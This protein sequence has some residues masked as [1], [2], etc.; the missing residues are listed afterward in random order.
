MI[1]IMV[2][3]GFF[4]LGE[5]YAKLFGCSNSVADMVA[6]GFRIYAVTFLVMGYDVIN[7][8]YFY[9]LWRC[10]IISFDFVTKGNCVASGIYID[11]SGNIWYDR[12]MGGITLFGNF[13]CSSFIISDW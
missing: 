12:S 3:V 6:A 8:M 11:S 4:A 5:Y 13:D 7:S 1:G 2:A 9:K 10:K